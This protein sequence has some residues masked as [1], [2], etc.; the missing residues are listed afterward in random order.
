MN[1]LI[2]FLL[3]ESENVSELAYEK[4]FSL[5]LAETISLSSLLHVFIPQWVIRLVSFP[6]HRENCSFH[7]Y[8][9]SIEQHCDTCQAVTIHAC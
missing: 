8:F 1:N 4:R 7:L 3:R 9:F 6:A 5:S 2:H